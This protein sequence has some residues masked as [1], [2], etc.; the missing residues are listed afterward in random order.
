M[1]SAALK[2]IFTLTIQNSQKF[3]S[4][5]KFLVV[6]RINTYFWGG[7]EAYWS[8]FYEPKFG[9]KCSKMSN[10]FNFLS[11]QRL[12]TALASYTVMIQCQNYYP[13]NRQ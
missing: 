13:N 8:Q 6:Q 1:Q 11:R 4:Q 7:G 10:N 2:P 5:K 3:L 12:F 9:L